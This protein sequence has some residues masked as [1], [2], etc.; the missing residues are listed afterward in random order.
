[1]T[2]SNGPQDNPPTAGGRFAAGELVRT[3]FVLIDFENVNPTSLARLDGDHFNVLLFVGA[4]QSKVPLEL[5]TALQRLGNRAQYVKIA[6][7]G[8]N[9]LDFHIAYYMGE[10]VARHPNAYFHIISKDTGFD[11]LI[12][13]LKSRKILCCRSPKVDDIPLMKAGDTQ[14]PN[15]RAQMLIAK[16]QLP[17]AT[18]PRTAKTLSSTIAAF[19]RKQLAE[20]EIADVITAM[21]AIGFLTVVDGKISYTLSG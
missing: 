8:R 3:N 5:A 18:K 13:H 19:F 14:S 4:H 16:L 21:Q 6:G 12:Q 1:V 7:S 9:A 10:L 20:E 15:E 2:N 17:K 11:P